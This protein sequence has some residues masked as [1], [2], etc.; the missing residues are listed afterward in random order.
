MWSWAQAWGRTREVRTRGHFLCLSRV[1]HLSF[2]FCLLFFS[3]LVSVPPNPLSL[4]PLSIPLPTQALLSD[5]FLVLS[6]VMGVR[7]QC[8][9]GGPLGLSGSR[10]SKTGLWRGSWWFGM[11]KITLLGTG[12]QQSRCS[13]RLSMLSHLGILVPTF[14]FIPSIQS[15]FQ[16]TWPGSLWWTLP[17]RGCCSPTR[18]L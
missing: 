14:H 17:F 4:W 3:L 1:H 8:C 7:V 13:G 12:S 16:D 5:S 18:M 6:P 15:W 11:S 2:L 9:V 10:F